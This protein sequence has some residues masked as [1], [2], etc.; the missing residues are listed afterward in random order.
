MSAFEKLVELGYPPNRIV[1]LGI[2]AGGNLALSIARELQKEKQV[3]PLAVVCMSPWSDLTL[4]GESIITLKKRDN[5]L[6]ASYLRKAAKAYAANMALDDPAV[7]P[8]FADYTNFCPVL[9][10]AGSEE[11]LL[12]DSVRL[13]DRISAAGTA[14]KLHVF[15]HQSHGFQSYSSPDSY[16]ALA[17]VNKFIQDLLLIQNGKEVEKNANRNS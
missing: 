15:E 13:Y 7:S 9:I 4:S 6:R 1:I 14:A 5:S 8:L 17:E 2:S 16:T 11:I 3:L 12:S 10:Q